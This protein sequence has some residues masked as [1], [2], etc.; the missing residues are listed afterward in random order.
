MKNSPLQLLR[1]VVPEASCTATPT[2][3]PA[4]PSEGRA[5]DQLAVSVVLSQQ[6]ASKDFP[7]HPWSLE[8][9]VSQTLKEGQNFPYTFKVAL[10]GFFLCHPDTLPHVSGGMKVEENR[11]FEIP[12]SSV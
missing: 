4:K 1:Y 11:R 12:G 9:S 3:D 7:G 5:L 8:M 10:I 2:F 6:E